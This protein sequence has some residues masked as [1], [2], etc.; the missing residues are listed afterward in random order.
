MVKPT[1]QARASCPR[2]ARPFLIAF[3]LLALALLSSC[4]NHSAAGPMRRDHSLSGHEF[5]SWET[6]AQRPST[7]TDTAGTAGWSQLDT[8]ILVQARRLEADRVVETLWAV[9]STT[10]MLGSEWKFRIWSHGGTLTLLSLERTQQG[11]GPGAPISRGAFLPHLARDLPALLGTR[12]VEVTLRLHRE[13]TRWGVALATASRGAP[14]VFARMLPSARGGTSPQAYQQALD[15][16]RRIERLMTMPRGG[17]TQFELQVMLEDER[18]VGWA[19]GAV[20]TR[21]NGPLLA[22]PAEAVTSVVRTLLPFTYGLGERTVRLTLDG[23]HQEAERRPRWSVVE[24]RTREP[25]PPPR[26]VAD[27]HRE[28]RAMH[29]YILFEF[30]EQ[31]RET[32]VLAASISVEQLAYS[33]VG[34]LLL[35]GIGVI[36]GKAAPTVVSVLSQGGKGAVRWFRNLLIRAPQKDRELLA[37]LWLKVET[38]GF[39]ALTD[40]E[41]Q[42]L[43]AVM[44]RLE[45]LLGSPL[46]KDAKRE[47]RRWSR[48]EYFELHN[49]KLA[50]LLGTE[51]MQS[52]E[53]HHLYPMEYA[54]HFPALDINGK[55]NLV[56][57]HR[58]VHRSLNTVWRSLREVSERMKTQDVKRAV[59]ITDRYYRRWFDKVY[60]PN[61]AAVLVHAEKAAIQEVAELKVLLSP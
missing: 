35:K 4:A 34:G 41:K 52:Y 3:V 49:P 26:E 2:T 1:M 8:D 38:Q 53:V 39:K 23:I 54:H 13:E 33:I 37:R 29:E 44:A 5:H 48:R 10:N 43:R 7:G 22:A 32:A 58:D 30:Q 61:D 6:D 11:T 40:V 57:V 21:G 51:G 20:N 14:P 28:Y 25:P 42:E 50:K 27:F 55:T 47:L 59:D 56:G 60:D 31:S 9:A 16:S 45:N 36:V 46:D 17:R 12:P 24:A 18:I 19:P 15:A